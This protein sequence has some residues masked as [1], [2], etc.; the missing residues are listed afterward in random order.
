MVSVIFHR[1]VPKK[2]S[3]WCRSSIRQPSLQAAV[4]QGCGVFSLFLSESTS[5]IRF[6]IFTPK[7]P[8]KLIHGKKQQTRDN[9]TKH[10]YMLH[11][12]VYY[13]YIA[14]WTPKRLVYIGGAHIGAGGVE[15]VKRQFHRKKKGLNPW[16][17]VP[18]SQWLVRYDQFGTI[19]S[20]FS[21]KAA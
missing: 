14:P 10:L 9:L 21:R 17:E 2:W 20:V 12:Y 13:I 15:Y 19:G 4:L 7:K 18:A 3:A 1:N 8:I 5:L 6:L 11:I 16:K